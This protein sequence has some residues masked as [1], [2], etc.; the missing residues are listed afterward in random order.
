MLPLAGKMETNEIRFVVRRAI[1]GDE[2]VLRALR[3]QALSD[4]PEAFGSTY[5]RELAR[6]AEDW[7]RWL[8][9]AVTFILE[10]NGEPRGLV[11]GIPDPQD[12]SVVHLRAMWVHPDLRGTGAAD[13]L[14]SSVKT[15]ASEL[16]ANQVR[17]QV[18]ESNV[19]ARRCYERVG[20]RATDRDTGQTGTVEIEMTWD[21]SP[22]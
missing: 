6:T 14:V 1:P 10:A 21:A 5:E 20:F 18:F 2:R 12:W 17:L 16:G 13:A 3:L 11:A 22:E 7:R 8:A 19:R 15:W 4:A 9:P